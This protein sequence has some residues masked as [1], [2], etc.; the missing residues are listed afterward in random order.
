MA[1][2]NTSRN[3]RL[4]ACRLRLRRAMSRGLPGPDTDHALHVK[5]TGAFGLH[6]SPVSQRCR[7]PSRAK[8]HSLPIKDAGR[9]GRLIEAWRGSKMGPFA[10]D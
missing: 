7:A 9:D 1:D 6:A 4:E 3:V 8:R 10:P 5:A 2:L